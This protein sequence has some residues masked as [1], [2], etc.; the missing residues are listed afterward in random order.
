MLLNIQVAGTRTANAENVLFSIVKAVF[1]Q[2]LKKPLVQ[3]TKQTRIQSR[4]K[5]RR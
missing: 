3:K 4:L 5:E 1:P 2:P